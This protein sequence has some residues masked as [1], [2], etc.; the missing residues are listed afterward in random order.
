MKIVI[1]NNL[2][3]PYHRGGAEIVV[4][5]IKK[6]LE[7][8]NHQVLV[9]STYPSFFAYKKIKII[10]DNYFLP[11]T[12]SLL[13]KIPYF[14]RLFWHLYKLI[15]I[16]Q[17]FKLKKILQQEKPKLILSHNLSA[18]SGLTNKLIKKLSIEQI[19]FL[20]DTQLLHP[21]GRLI[22]NNEKII[23]SF[24]AKIWQFIKKQQFKSIKKVVSPSA[25]LLKLHQE[26]GFFN[27]SKKHI[28]INPINLPKLNKTKFP[29]FTFIYL[30]QLDEDKGL[31]LLVSA[32]E[33]IPTNSNLMIIGQGPLLQFIKE[34][35]KKNNKIILLDNLNHAE[36][37]EILSQSHCLVV[38]SLIYENCSTAI[39][40]G[41]F[42]GL[43]I[44][45]SD[46]G[47]SPELID[48]FWGQSFQAGNEN[49]LYQK[50]LQAIKTKDYEKNLNSLKL[51]DSNN[52]I[53][54]LLNFL[55]TP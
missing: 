54:D 1:L 27:K 30:G 9:I 18:F 48:K 4:S 34:K 15:D 24:S 13:N 7:K 32:F 38:P 11:S 20:H 51:L 43:N 12:Y 33:R 55:I 45:S 6:A 44:I 46:I 42:Q 47:G 17:I 8:E 16:I 49:D 21:S 50:M 28:A 19:H 53:Q 41:V 23:N 36:A 39:L 10:K 25:W 29:V 5:T 31:P 26:K 3:E 52:Y 40:E 2:H 22:L 14:C 37:I 35:S